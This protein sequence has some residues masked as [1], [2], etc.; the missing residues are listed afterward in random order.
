[1]SK[2]EIQTLI[3]DLCLEMESLWQKKNYVCSDENTE[4]IVETRIQ[5]NAIVLPKS[6]L[7][8]RGA[9]GVDIHITYHKSI[10]QTIVSL[11]RDSLFR[12]EWNKDYFDIKAKILDY[13]NRLIDKLATIPN[14]LERVE[15]SLTYKY[16]EPEVLAEKIRSDGHRGIYFNFSCYFLPRLIAQ[17][18]YTNGFDPEK[19]LLFAAWDE[20]ALRVTEKIYSIAEKAHN[21]YEIVIFLSA[22]VLDCKSPIKF[23]KTATIE[24]AS[25]DLLSKL[26]KYNKDVRLDYINTAIQLKISVSVNA[27]VEKYQDQ[28]E[29]GAKAAEA[30]VD[31]FRLIRDE[32]IGVNALHIFPVDDFTP[33][34]RNYERSYQPDLAVFYPKRFH[35]HNEK[36]EPLQ[37]EDFRSFHEILP[38][39]LDLL[40]NLNSP[41]SIQGFGVAIRR[42]RSTYER[43][44]PDD[45]ERLLD[46]GIAFEAIFLNDGN[47]QELKYRLSLRAAK[48]LGKTLEERRSIFYI[49][50]NLYDLR[51]AIAHGGTVNDKKRNDNNKKL[52]QVLAHAPKILKKAIIEMILG[53]APRGLTKEKLQNWWLDLELGMDDIAQ[54]S[55]REQENNKSENEPV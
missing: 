44:L 43:Y 15:D 45:P 4:L 10:K 40:V 1:M 12:D 16:C 18:L 48:L 50:K 21:E 46:I 9:V 6:Q 24:Y 8:I 42:F 38:N 51:S 25:D 36:I 37:I 7:P 11:I 55:D 2:Q 47:H 27:S 41:K 33:H 17:E 35:F 54:V 31:C 14:L 30:L 3:T 52:E 53:N 49:I 29:A 13:E 22:P 34:I 32:D 39:Y 20:I 23:F 5:N 26:H 28:Y 19:K